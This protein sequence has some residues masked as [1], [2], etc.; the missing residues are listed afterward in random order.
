MAFGGAYA[1]RPYT[2][3]WKINTFSGNKV[4]A[5]R[6]R[7]PDVPFMERITWKCDAFSDCTIV[8][9]WKIDT[10]RA[11]TILWMAFGV[12]YSYCPDLLFLSWYKKRRQKKIKAPTGAEEIGRVRVGAGKRTV[13]LGN[14]V[15]AYCIRPTNV[16]SMERITWKKWCVL[17]L[18]DR[19]NL[20]NWRVSCICYPLDGVRWGVCNTPLLWYFKTHQIQM[21]L[22]EKR[23]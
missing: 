15:G 9:T 18:Y 1:I 21:L 5:Y 16:P 4:G 7:P 3:T 11:F 20:K 22:P 17:G 12:A 2:G 19:Y 14:T 23:S 13:F 8:I 6:I 10:F